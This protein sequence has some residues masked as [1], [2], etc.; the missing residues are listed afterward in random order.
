VDGNRT[1][2]LQPGADPN[3]RQ[4]SPQMLSRV[5]SMTPAP[6]PHRRSPRSISLRRCGHG[7][8]GQVYLDADERQEREQWG[9]TR[10]L[11]ERAPSSH[12][13]TQ[14]ATLALRPSMPSSSASTFSTLRPESSCAR[15][16]RP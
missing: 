4:R 8:D 15:Y 12:A 11:P 6:Q 3:A 2:A 1:S 14:P 7:E 10:A 16:H 9:P 5:P 13:C